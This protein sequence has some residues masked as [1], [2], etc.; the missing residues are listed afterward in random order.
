MIRRQWDRDGQTNGK[1]F[2]D[3]V[4]GIWRGG[5][6]NRESDSRL[7]RMLIEIPLVPFR[8]SPASIPRHVRSHALIKPSRDV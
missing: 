4:S 8:V 2:Y 7:E 6:Y 3:F 1:Q 5:S